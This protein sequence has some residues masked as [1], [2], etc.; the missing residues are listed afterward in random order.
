[1]C[2]YDINPSLGGPAD[3]TLEKNEVIDSTQ[4]PRGSSYPAESHQGGGSIFS[5][6]KAYNRRYITPHMEFQKKQVR[7][8]RSGFDRGVPNPGSNPHLKER[9]EGVGNIDF[10]RRYEIAPVAISV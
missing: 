3:L 7:C 6:W 5:I 8:G 4:Q 10:N 1:M 9:D 2:V